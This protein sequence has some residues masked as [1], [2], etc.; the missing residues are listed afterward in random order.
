MNS[1]LQVDHRRFVEDEQQ[2]C[3]IYLAVNL[4]FPKDRY[5]YRSCLRIPGERIG[6]GLEVEGS[7]RSF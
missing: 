5:F 7:V 1:L 6:N 2:L 4:Y 3:I